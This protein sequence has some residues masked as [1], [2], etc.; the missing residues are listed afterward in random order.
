MVAAG[1]A[2]LPA[3]LARERLVAFP[4]VNYYQPLPTWL[5]WLLLMF[6]FALPASSLIGW[7]AVWLFDHLTRTSGTPD[8]S[9][10]TE[11]R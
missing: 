5:I 4:L 10:N 11:T 1:H 9:G 7:L 2:A 8:N 3:Q 6:A